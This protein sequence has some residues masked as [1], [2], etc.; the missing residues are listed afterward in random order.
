MPMP[1]DVS[2]QGLVLQRALPAQMPEQSTQVTGSQLV[3]IPS[4]S[5]AGLLV[6]IPFVSEL[7][8]GAYNQFQASGLGR[9]Y[10]ALD[11]MAIVQQALADSALLKN[12]TGKISLYPV[13]YLAEC[14]DGQYRLSLAGRIEAGNWVGRYVTHLPT[15]YGDAELAAAA[16]ATLATMQRELA[17][18]AQTLRRLM[19]GD[20]HGDFSKVQYRADLGSL[21]L[22]CARA[23]GLVSANLM[24]ARGAEVVE[25][26]AAHVVVRIDGDL[27]Q[28]GPSGGLLYGLHYLRK[29]QLH[30]FG[31]KAP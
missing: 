9:H 20:A 15:T 16:P 11:V 28:A 22:A 19:E 29:D 5:A 4:E 2:A 23:A 3:L 26:D 24:L 17:A 14:S 18:A 10:G 7:A 30:T 13:L 6:P 27:S 31:K 8:T 25:D 1:P 21:H 12:G